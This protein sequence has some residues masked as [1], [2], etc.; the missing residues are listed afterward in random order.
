MQRLLSLSDDTRLYVGHDYPDS[1][2]EQSCF[3]TV[4]DERTSNKHGKSGTDVGHFIK[5]RAERD[6][7]LGTPRL[8]HP[9]L[10]VNI[11]AGRLPPADEMGRVFFKIP[12]K[13]T[14]PL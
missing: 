6:A 12:V 14:V 8:L 4:L 5:W 3:A 11:R 7:T 1:T 2:R 9:A 10:Q 13:S